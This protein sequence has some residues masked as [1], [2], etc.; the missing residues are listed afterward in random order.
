MKHTTNLQYSRNLQYV[1]F[2]IIL[3]ISFVCYSQDKPHLNDG[4]GYFYSSSNGDASGPMLTTVP[5]SYQENPERQAL[6]NQLREARLN[7]NV[8]KA[9][10][11]QR[12]LNELDGVQPVEYINNPLE[13]GI[14]Q[15]HQQFTGE[16]DGISTIASNNYWAIATQTS[17]KSQ[18][19]FTAVSEFVPSAGDQ[20]K[21]YVS[22]NRGVSWVLKGTWSSFGNGVRCTTDEL[23]IEPVIN[24][25]DTLLFVVSGY[26]YNNNNFTLIARFNIGTGVVYGQSFS[27]SSTTTKN[28]SPRV[29]SD[30]TVFGGNAYVYI[31]VSNDTMLG[32]NN[33]KLRQRLCIIQDP[34]TAFTQTH[35][36]V[37]PAGG[38]FYWHYSGAPDNSYFYQDVAY[39]F[40]STDNIYSATIFPG[41]NNVY[42]AWSKNTGGSIAGSL[43]ITE[44]LPISRVRIAFNGGGGN[45][46]GAIIYLR[47]YTSNPNG[48]V[49]VKCQN[50][51]SGGIL[52]SSFTASYVEFTTDTATTCDIQA[53][54]IANNKFKFAYGVRGSRCYY[55]S[56]TSTTSYSPSLQV[57]NLPGIRVKAGYRIAP[58]DS[59]LSIWSKNDG[60]GM[61]S[62]YGCD[63][64][65]GIIQNGNTVPEAYTLSQNYP[66]P[67]NPVTNIK[68]SVP[69]A[70]IVK[71][72]V[73]DLLGN[74]VAT[75]VSQQMNAGSY[76]VDF[77]AS[78]LS[79][80]VYF[81][82]IQ[83]GEFTAIKKMM[84]VK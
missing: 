23:D 45:R 46:N 84:L 13:T 72:V 17:N 12:R 64:F 37:N 74:E 14:Q 28:Y 24:G 47:N 2:I 59:C 1:F 10:E 18:H 60:T 65:T 53:V 29:T 8:S 25:T 62:T 27:L 76:T 33:H 15:T 26:S 41:Y 6:L 78:Q 52:L 30:N 7:N 49:D 68:F 80:S 67:F 16:G 56:N 31:T 83:A 63:N 38:G 75:L 54:K 21:V 61:Y 79:S 39:Y 69:Q 43:I 36:I 5:G 82:K 51:T 20:I 81:Y 58:T 73:Y 40:D 35:K 22:Y 42:T 4:T 50:T 9:K 57:N 55:R 48:D 71:L 3:L 66:N 19:I 32:T 70:G 11:I 77:D 44:T 34:F